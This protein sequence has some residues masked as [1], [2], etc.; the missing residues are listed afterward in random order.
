MLRLLKNPVIMSNDLVEYY[1][2]QYDEGSRH[3]DPF[4]VIQEL[5]TKFLLS[6]YLHDDPMS[7]LDVGGANGV[8]SFFL[9]D[10]GHRVSLLDI[11]PNHIEQA[12]Q[13]NAE[14][15]RKLEQILLGDVQTFATSARYDLILLHGPLYHM[16]VREKRIA[17]LQRMKRLLKA[18][19]RILGFG[20]NRYAGYFYGVHSGQI[21]KEDYRQ[22]VKEE[23]KN[24]I[25]HKAPSWYFHTPDELTAEFEEAGL[26]VA[27]IKSV[28][29]QVW[30]LPGIG[31]MIQ[32]VD[33][34]RLILQ[35]A[36]EAE[37]AVQIGQDLLCVGEIPG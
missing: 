4:G 31:T 7:I 13:L 11:A 35:L 18:N 1:V 27:A 16:I 29:T 20:I 33:S 12:E 14:R 15:E 23:M 6:R 17:V 25:R 22:I 26:A 9:A 8:Y 30:M 3:R 2:N 37:D 36:Q 24:G 28:T 10:L 32:D 34:L 5:R 21:L 19:G